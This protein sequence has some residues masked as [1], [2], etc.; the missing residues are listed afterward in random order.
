MNYTEKVLKIN[1]QQIVDAVATHLYATSIIDDDVDITNI[2]F[3]DLFGV[4]TQEFVTLKIF[5]KNKREVI[6]EK[7]QINK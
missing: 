1:R 2:Q 7:R 6:A 4:S 3:S 5:T